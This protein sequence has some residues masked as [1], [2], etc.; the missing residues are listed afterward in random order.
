MQNARAN[1]PRRDGWIWR[2]D[3]QSSWHGG[4]SYLARL[5]ITEKNGFA[6][7]SSGGLI[8]AISGSAN[9]AISKPGP[10]GSTPD[11]RRGKIGGLGMF[12]RDVGLTL[13]VNSAIGFQSRF[14]FE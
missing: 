10:I 8:A 4:D 2:I 12:V 7:T 3:G 11:E 1:A 9:P 6:R 14:A 13:S 5:L